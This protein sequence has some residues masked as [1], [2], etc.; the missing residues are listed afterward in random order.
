MAT[1][2]A[3]QGLLKHQLMFSQGALETGCTTIWTYK[4]EYPVPAQRITDEQGAISAWV[5]SHWRGIT[6]T[7]TAANRIKTWDFGVTPPLKQ[8]DLLL[9]PQVAGT[10]GTSPF[11]A[12]SAVVAL[13]TQPVGSAVRNRN[14]GRIYHPISSGQV[15]FPEGTVTTAGVI[16]AYHNLR[17]R[18]DPAADADVGDWV[19]VSFF[20]GGAVRP[21]PLTFGVD[22]CL[23][24]SRIGF[25]LSRIEDQPAFAIGA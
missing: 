15:T 20:N 16:T 13:R 8:N 9:S 22:H 21:V 3:L 19:V 5:T 10:G 4:N 2:P 23:V 14:N 18:L 25:Q 7:G 11:Y 6:G 17:D 12:C 24:R 1:R